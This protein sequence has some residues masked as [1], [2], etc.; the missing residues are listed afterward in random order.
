[1]LKASTTDNV[2][3]VKRLFNEGFS[4]GH[5]DVLDEIFDP[6]LTFEDPSLPP[7]IEGIKAI[8]RKNNSSFA[9]WHF[10]LDE[11]V[12]EDNKVAVRWTGKGTHVASFAGETPTHKLIQLHGISIYYLKE[13]RIYADKVIVDNLAFLRELGAMPDFQMVPNKT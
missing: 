13:G 11:I 6:N 12:A 10:V 4:G 3:V 2:A 8:V 5:E 9:N 1:M 7:G